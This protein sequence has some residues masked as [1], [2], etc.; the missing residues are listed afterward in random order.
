ERRLY[1]EGNALNARAAQEEIIKYESFSP[2]I[3]SL[4]ELRTDDTMKWMWPEYI[5]EDSKSVSS[6]SIKLFTLSALAQAYSLSMVGDSKPTK[7]VDAGAST[8]VEERETFCTAFWRKVSDLFTKVWLPDPDQSATD[9]LKY[10]EECRSA[11][12][13]VLFSAIFLQALG[14][15]CQRIGNEE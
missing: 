3:V 9:R 2:V 4:Q 7:K 10:L 11:D 6:S 12:R 5:E 15:V 8:M 13:N 14:Q 1:I